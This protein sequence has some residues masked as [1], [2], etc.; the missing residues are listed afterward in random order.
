MGTQTLE[1]FT[2]TTVADAAEAMGIPSGVLN[3][4]IEEVR[5]HH[6]DGKY[7]LYALLP[8]DTAKVHS[9]VATVSDGDEVEVEVKGRRA[10]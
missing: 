7:G 6:A 10:Q 2:G 9:I 4:W 3:R 8:S 5:Q 1:D